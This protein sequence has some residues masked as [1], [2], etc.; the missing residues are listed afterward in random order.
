[1]DKDFSEYMNEPYADED[2]IPSTPMLPAFPIYPG[3][4][5]FPNIPPYPLP[6][7]PFYHLPQFGPKDLAAWFVKMNIALMSV[8]AALHNMNLKVMRYPKML[9][10][11]IK[12]LR[13]NIK[14]LNDMVV[15][16]NNDLELIKDKTDAI[17]TIVEQVQAT[18][19]AQQL[20]ID[21]LSTRVQTSELNVAA[22]DTKVANLDAQFTTV[23]T[24][25]KALK[26]NFD[27]LNV[28]FKSMEDRQDLF[29]N[30]IDSVE[31]KAD[32]A[33]KDLSNF[34]TETRDKFDTVNVSLNDLQD[35]IT[36]ES[37]RN[38]KQDAQIQNNSTRIDTLNNDVAA[39]ET[40]HDADLLD[41]RSDIVNLEREDAR[42]NI[43]VDAVLT[44]FSNV[45]S[46]A[47][48]AKEKAD[49]VTEN[50]DILRDS[51]Q[52]LVDTENGHNTRLTNLEGRA[53]TL[54]ARADTL[55]SDV[56]DN[57]DNITALDTR[58]TALE[59]RADGND[60]TIGTINRT[61]TSFSNI[62]T[63]LREDLDEAQ[64][65]VGSLQSDMI[66]AQATLTSFSNITRD[67]R[68]DVDAVDLK[69][70]TLQTAVDVAQASLTSAQT[71]IAQLKTNVT[72]LGES[73]K[74]VKTSADKS[75]NTLRYM[76]AGS[77]DDTTRS[78]LIGSVGILQSVKE[79][80]HRLNSVTS[81]PSEKVV[82]GTDFKV[83]IRIN[84][85]TTALTKSINADV[86]TKA[87]A[88]E[89]GTYIALF[90]HA[91][92]KIGIGR[93]L[94]LGDSTLFGYLEAAE[95]YLILTVCERIAES[96][97]VT[98]EGSILI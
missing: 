91:Y 59:V 17:T 50:F 61:L 55:E 19:A 8:D 73:I 83:T 14:E 69:A 86:V 53:S 49:E 42:I 95:G 75:A 62:T 72:V 64:M 32:D 84:M 46:M 16:N 88:L 78:I 80:F 54:E 1:M 85:D 4:C 52:N 67:L 77:V 29:D 63:E 28:T 45:K 39:L 48:E 89:A 92:E 41:V 97:D 27:A 90:S 3:A 20:Q 11:K 36:E 43:R 35:A 96:A 38:T 26:L 74:D 23:S 24:E 9:E 10:E 58:V 65:N 79:N 57:T 40:K 82:F 31:A 13:E 6:V 5:T 98:F 87:S 68:A 30:R 7:T 47:K 94:L 66:A 18:I 34:M 51:V 33:V 37:K 22:M 2:S 93:I 60:R 76:G 71:D 56:N 70:D 21:N 12:Q 25:F 81:M 44:S 15:S